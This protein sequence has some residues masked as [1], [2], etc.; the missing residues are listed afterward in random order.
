MKGSNLS[1]KIGSLKFSCKYEILSGVLES[2]EFGEFGSVSVV[3]CSSKNIPFNCSL[4]EW[5]LECS[6]TSTV[7]EKG[8]I[9]S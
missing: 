6:L 8:R 9:S 5:C 4:F 3:V 2:V 1:L 7:S